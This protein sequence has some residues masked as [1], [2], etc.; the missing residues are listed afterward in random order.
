MQQTSNRKNFL[1]L[2]AAYTLYFPVFF[3]A[4]VPFGVIRIKPYAQ[5]SNI[6]D[7]DLFYTAEQ[8]YQRLALFGEQGRAV[9]TSTF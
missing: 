1:V 4:D 9:F 5:G 8:A 6:L 3:F 2:L 7:V